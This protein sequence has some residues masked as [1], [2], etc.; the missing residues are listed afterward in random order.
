[1]AQK[2][3]LGNIVNVDLGE[4]P[5]EVKGHEQGYERPCVIVKVFPEM[6][7]AIV[8]PCTS[9]EPRYNHFTIV[10]VPQGTGGLTMDSY[11]L[12][13]QIRT[14]SYDRILTIIGSMDAKNM[15][16]IRSV[17]SDSLGL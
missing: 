1:M 17:L 12:C 14:I 10:K 5:Y 13:H 8:L 2:Y 4:P 6:K 11:V 9:K 16:K 3:Q 15:L 7:L